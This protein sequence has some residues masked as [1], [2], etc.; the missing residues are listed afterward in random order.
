MNILME[1]HDVDAENCFLAAILID[2]DIFPEV[3]IEISP[4]YFSDIKNR[5]IYSSCL[6]LIRNNIKIDPITV[7]NHL[8]SSGDNN[9]DLKQHIS[10]IYETVSDGSHAKFHA[11]IIKEK[12]KLRVSVA[13]ANRIIDKI[14]GGCNYEIIQTEIFRFSETIQQNE[15]NSMQDVHALISKNIEIYK[16]A[17]KDGTEIFEGLKTGFAAIDKYITLRKHNIYIIAGRPGKGK[18]SLSLKIADNIVSSGKRVLFFSAEMSKEEI[19]EKLVCMKSMISNVAM[20]SLSPAEKIKKYENTLKFYKEHKNFFILEESVV[21]IEQLLS[22]AIT[23]MYQFPDIALIVADYLQLFSCERGSNRNA[24]LTE[25]LR[26][27]NLLTK[28]LGIPFLWLSQLNRKVEERRDKR[29]LLSDL[30]ESG[31]IEQDAAAVMFLYRE[32]MYNAVF[33]DKAKTE[34]IFA[35]NRFGPTGTRFLHFKEEFTLFTDYYSTGN[36]SSNRPFVSKEP[37]RTTKESQQRDNEY[38]TMSFNDLYSPKYK[39]DKDEESK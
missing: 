22:V 28:K 14:K 25:I 15:S 4:E 33:G 18:T 26:L 8:E 16:Q 39:D 9:P 12:W 27:T 34:I 11:K 35:K 20:K 38:R 23:R 29:P 10:D 37:S 7:W 21:S 6:S 24:E 13:M 2:P 30:R 3:S 1:T 19:T 32:S 31:A 17:E 36:V 5:K